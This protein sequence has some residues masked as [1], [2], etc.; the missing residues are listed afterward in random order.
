MIELN[1]NNFHNFLKQQDKLVIVDFW[2]PWCGLCT[3]QKEIMLSL[4]KQSKNFIVA[5][6]NVDSD[7]KIV[8]EY[9]IYSIPAIY[10]FK[11]N[12]LLYKSEGKIKNEKLLLKE[13]ASF[14][15]GTVD[16]FT[17]SK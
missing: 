11:N 7:R 13:I 14:S 10:I 4:E 5:S 8:E 15:L 17:S 2:A 12:N 1:D 6:L 3:I 16:I 9:T